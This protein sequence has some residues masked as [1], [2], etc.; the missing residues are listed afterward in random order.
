MQEERIKELESHVKA[1][2]EERV[3]AAAAV[4]EAEFIALQ[5]Q[6]ETAN[7][8]VELETLKTKS[9]AEEKEHL[10]S[11]VSEREKHIASLEASVRSLEADCA[12]LEAD[13]ASTE[14]EIVAQIARIAEL[15]AIGAAAI[16]AEAEA[17]KEKCSQLEKEISELKAEV[18]IHQE[19]VAKKDLSLAEHTAELAQLLQKH[20]AWKEKH[21]I[22]D[23]DLQSIKVKYEELEN[24]IDK[25]EA[26][27]AEQQAKSEGD[28]RQIESLNVRL[29]TSSRAHSDAESLVASLREQ[30]ATLEKD[31]VNA[32]LSA[33]SAKAENAGI[34]LSLNS[35]ESLLKDHQSMLLAKERECADLLVKY[36]LLSKEA[37]SRD[38][39]VSEYEKE[40]QQIK[41][42][43]AV[44]EARHSDKESAL[45][46]VDVKIRQLENDRSER[47]AAIKELEAAAA[48]AAAAAAVQ[49]KEVCMYLIVML[50]FGN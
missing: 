12:A 41:E 4:N 17:S 28:Q 6:I 45:K 34:R 13:K 18:Q 16:A 40:M 42:S 36:E 30:I 15:E 38:V 11:T 50:L 39:K 20:D 22:V 26:L 1:L 33:E 46:E 3:A 27:K 43:R 32:K 48:I 44:A 24:M 35:L 31:L 5:E 8:A 10:V 25:Y 14:S 19:E 29:E 9:L 47:D 49:A 37:G 7:Q 2:E 21:D 23:S